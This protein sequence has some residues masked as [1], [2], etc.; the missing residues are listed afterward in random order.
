MAAALGGLD[1]LAFTGGVGERSA[2]IRQRGVAGLEFMGI[3]IDARLNDSASDEAEITL[4]RARVRTLVIRAREDLEIARQTRL[5]LG[6][7]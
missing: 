3:A 2:E 7:T 4:A 5:V 1:V 6:A